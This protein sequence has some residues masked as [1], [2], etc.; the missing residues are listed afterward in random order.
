MRLKW[1]SAYEVKSEFRLPLPFLW[2]ARVL[3]TSPGVREMSQLFIFCKLIWFLLPVFI[4]LGRREASPW[5]DIPKAHPPPSSQGG[6]KSQGFSFET[7]TRKPW[8]LFRSAL[9]LL[10]SNDNTR[11]GGL[12]EWDVEREKGERPLKK[13]H[14]HTPNKLDSK[15]Y[16]DTFLPLPHLTL[17][18]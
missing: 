5:I 2:H 4:P 18:I 1:D 10:I 11:T 17:P 7:L 15:Y 3:P 6:A 9:P 12:L 13:K 16:P 8:T 14:T